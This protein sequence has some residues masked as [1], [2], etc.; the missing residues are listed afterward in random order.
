MLNWATEE[1]PLKKGVTG[2]IHYQVRQPIRLNPSH[3]FLCQGTCGACWAF[4]A[5]ASTEAA[6]K[7]SLL[8]SR[9]ESSKNL[10]DQIPSLSAQELIDCDDQF[11]RGCRGGNPVMA[12][13]YIAENGLGSELSYPYDERLH[14]RCDFR[15]NQSRY[16]I[17]RIRR[18]VARNE[19]AIRLALEDGP[20]SVGVCGT[21]L[22]F[23]FYASGIFDFR[24]CCRVQNH[25]MLIVGYGHDPDLGL[26]YWIAQNS[27]GEHWGENGF[28]RILR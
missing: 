3:L 23:L 15:A 21:D 26:D 18:I 8:E 9:D 10:A 6:I 13:S 7:I 14:E 1:N 4:V 17:S 28:M 12:F 16:F 20:V 22:P 5:T 25:A 2:T 11:N 24:E 19:N 27:W